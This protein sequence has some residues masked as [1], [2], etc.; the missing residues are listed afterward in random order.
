MAFDG[1]E[2]G[3]ELVSRFLVLHGDCHGV[4]VVQHQAEVTGVLVPDAVGI[5]KMKNRKLGIDFPKVFTYLQPSGYTPLEFA[6]VVDDRLLENR[7]ATE[8]LGLLGSGLSGRVST[9]RVDPEPGLVR[10]YRRS[11]T[12]LYHS[13]DQRVPPRHRHG[14]RGRSYAELPS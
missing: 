6:L 14:W 12:A 2:I 3:S 10:W 8:G 4:P 9:G 13:P 7:E 5:G 11:F 1:F